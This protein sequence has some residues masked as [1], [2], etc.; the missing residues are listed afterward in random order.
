MSV[1]S[2]VGTSGV[3]VLDKSVAVLAALAERGTAD[4]G[5][6][7]GGHRAAPAH[8]PP[9]GR[10]PRGSP[11]GGPRRRPAG[12]GS[13]CASWAGPGRPAPRLELVEAARPVLAR[14]RDETGESAQLFVRDGDRRVCVAAAERASGLRD[15]VPVGSVLPLDRGSGGKVLLA[16]GADAAGRGHRRRVRGRA[17]AGLGGQRGRAG[18]GR[19]QRQCPGPRRGRPGCG[20]RWASAAPSSASAASPA[21]TWP[22]P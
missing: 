22:A 9:P 1:T 18:G 11:P 19:G 14:L 13:A 8:R 16:F 21:A 15:T 6:A 5:W 12:T 7:G 17:P 20:P 2:G 10:R 4:P 3:G